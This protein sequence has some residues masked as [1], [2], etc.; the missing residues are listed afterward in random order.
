MFTS[1][2]NVVSILSINTHD[3]SEEFYEDTFVLD[4]VLLAKSQSESPKIILLH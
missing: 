2:L 3:I 1:F 4:L